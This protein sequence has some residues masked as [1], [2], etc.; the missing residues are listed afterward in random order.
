MNKNNNINNNNTEVDSEDWHIMLQNSCLTYQQHPIYKN[1]C[2]LGHTNNTS[3]CGH[4]DTTN[5]HIMTDFLGQF[6]LVGEQ[7]KPSVKNISVNRSSNGIN[8]QHASNM[9]TS[10]VKKLRLA[11]F[12]PKISPS[13][14]YLLRI[15]FVGN[16]P[17]ALKG[18]ESIEESLGGI[19][20][21]GTEEFEFHG[22]N[23]NLSICV[24]ALSSGWQC[25]LAA[26]CQE[27]PFK[28]V[29]S[30]TQSFMHCS[31]SLQSTQANPSN[32]KCS[33]NI[34]QK[35]R[36]DLMKTF[37]IFNNTPESMT[38]SFTSHQAVPLKQSEAVYE[39]C[40][41]EGE[42]LVYMSLLNSVKRKVSEA[43]D[44]GDDWKSLAVLMGQDRYIDFFASKESPSE[45]VLNLWQV[46]CSKNHNNN[47][48][49]NKNNNENGYKFLFISSLIEHLKTMKMYGV[50]KTIENEIRGN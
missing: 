5:C 19:L 21:D 32:I 2:S 31:L 46:R 28:H 50:V 14:E 38:S 43:M 37:N 49:Y 48:N 45:S 41:D 22:S 26:N 12:A 15:Y 4:L 11:V 36:Q 40:G 33:L 7:A 18:V 20:L 24:D 47:N 10:V 29:W 27:I 39:R 42:D 34:F 17:D 13:V 30:N 35:D 1:V 25:K 23:Q 44:G 16:T 9:P 3:I 6:S 8:F